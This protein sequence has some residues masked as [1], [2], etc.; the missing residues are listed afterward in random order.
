VTLTNLE[1]MNP[2]LSKHPFRA[3]ILAGT[4]ATLIGLLDHAT[5]R[6]WQ[7][8]P[9]YLV[10]LGIA[11]WFSGRSWGVVFSVL[12]AAVWLTAA[13]LAVGPAYSHPAISFWNASMFLLIFVFITLLLAKLHEIM[14]TLEHRVELRTAQL[15]EEMAKRSEAELGWLQAERLAVVGSMAAQM[16]HEVRNP[17]CSISLNME[18]LSQE[19]DVLTAGRPPAAV[20]THALMTQIETEFGRINKVVHDYLGFARLPKTSPATH[21]LHAFLDENLAYM[22]AELEAANVKLVKDYDSSITM[23]KVDPA[24]MWQVLLNLIRNAREAMPKGGEL[25]VRT[26]RDGRETCI[27][28]SDTGC[29][30]G[31]SEM[32][33]LFSPFFTTK[34][35]GIGLGLAL[36]HQIVTEHGGHLRC[37]STPG[38]GTTFT[39]SLP[40]SVVSSQTHQPKTEST[41]PQPFHRYEFDLIR[42]AS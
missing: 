22:A 12:V 3:I 21:S 4:L 24:R 27:A 33:R 10:P 37:R 8:T 15:R 11:V 41:K 34:A 42:S 5:G 18:L 19:L 20:E 25:R 13:E 39:I 35:E 31:P 38:V 1:F 30:I 28:V 2:A 16:A 40:P 36:S 29:G 23:V 14:L 6:E 17:L 26:Y 9:L 7:I 32:P